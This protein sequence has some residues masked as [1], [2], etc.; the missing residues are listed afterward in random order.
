MID[1]H[2]AFQ[3]NECLIVFKLTIDFVKSSGMDF[4]SFPVPKSNICKFFCFLHE[5]TTICI[6]LGSISKDSPQIC[7]PDIFLI[8]CLS[9]ILL[10]HH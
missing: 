5:A 3:S 4:N 10:S 8:E 2:I 6:E 9:L 7:G 1:V